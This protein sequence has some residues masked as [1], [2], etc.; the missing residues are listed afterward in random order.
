MNHKHFMRQALCEAE[1]SLAAGEFPVGCVLTHGNE[2]ISRAGRTN[3]RDSAANELDHAEILALRAL[4]AKLPQI[5]AAE[6]VVYS[7]ME[8]CLMCFSTLLLNG[9]RTFVYAYEDA[10]GG[11]TN[12]P[13]AQLSPLYRQMQIQLVP[14][15]LR[16]ESLALFKKFFTDPANGYWQGSLLADYTLGQS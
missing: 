14:G 11:G 3:S 15:I 16:D 2:I 13:I 10:M 1:K 7:T 9:I 12:L 6:I 4:T 8:P 5:N